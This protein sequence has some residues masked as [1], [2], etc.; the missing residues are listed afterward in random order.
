MR[1]H[2]E[3]MIFMSVCAL[4]YAGLIAFFCGPEKYLP[5]LFWFFVGAVIGRVL[6]CLL[7]TITDIREK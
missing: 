2:I 6:I 4:A 1:E 7:V 5:S 3:F